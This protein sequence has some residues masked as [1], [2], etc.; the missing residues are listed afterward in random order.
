MVPVDLS[1]LMLQR[2]PGGV[3]I[4]VLL[5]GSRRSSLALQLLLNQSCFNPC[6]SGWFPS[7]PQCRPIVASSI[8]FQSLFFWMV[9]VDPILNRRVIRI[10]FCFNPCSSGWFPSMATSVKGAESPT[11]FQS[12]WKMMLHV[13]GGFQS[14]FFWMVPVDR[15]LEKNNIRFFGFNPC[16]SGW[17]PSIVDVDADTSW[18]TEFQS[19][20]FWMVPVDLG[21]GGSR[22][23]GHSFNPCSSG[24]FPS[25]QTSPMPCVLWVVS[26]LVLLD[27]SRR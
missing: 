1:G 12:F 6:S 7:I 25:I 17:F 24:W 23:Q 10:Q 18:A 22:G 26:I 27:G 4:L 3:S 2:C 14:L 9:P 13:Y 5:D 19:L 11:L 16:S 15:L 20:F 8:M 21:I